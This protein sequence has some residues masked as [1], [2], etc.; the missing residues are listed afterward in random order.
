[1]FSEAVLGRMSWLSLAVLLA[2]GCKTSEGGSGFGQGGGAVP[3]GFQAL[4]VPRADIPIGAIWMEGVGPDGAGQ[5]EENR[6]RTQSVA[7]LESDRSLSAGVEAAIARY[8]KLTGSGSERVKI[9]LTS[10]TIERVKSLANVELGSGQGLLY[11]GLRAGRITLTYKSTMEASVRAAASEQNLPITASVGGN[12]ENT[13]V[14]DGSGL[15]IGYRVVRLVPEGVDR[16]KE[17]LEDGRVRL[18][19]Y[20]IE[21]NTGPMIKC[22]CDTGR[23]GAAYDRCSREAPS[24]A[25]VVNV[26]RFTGTGGQ[27]YAEKFQ[28]PGALAGV[29]RVSLG[30]TMSDA[31]ISADT[32]N[33]WLIYAPMVQDGAAHGL[34]QLCSIFIEEKSYVELVRSRFRVQAVPNPVAPGW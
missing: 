15:F 22:Y 32:L 14:L 3:K 27:S 16:E 30:T 11:E 8:L 24:V 1:L 26:S 12:A 18:E 9:S 19:P 25:S 31:S 20:E 5:P 33:F 6:V 17:E 21:L 28:V 23:D 2:A 29:T 7:S 4:T 34:G 13:L 10:L